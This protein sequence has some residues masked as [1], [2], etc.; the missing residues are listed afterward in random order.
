[1]SGNRGELSHNNDL[2]SGLIASLQKLKNLETL[3][4]SRNRLEELPRE[5]AESLQNMGN[6]H[7]LDLSQNGLRILPE[8]LDFFTKLTSL[9]SLILCNNSLSELPPDFFTSLKSLEN[10]YVINLADNRLTTL[11]DNFRELPRQMRL[12]LSGNNFSSQEAERILNITREPGYNGPTINLSIQ[13][14][15]IELQKESHVVISEL[16]QIAKLPQKQLHLFDSLEL[17]SWLNRLSEIP[18]FSSETNRHILAKKIL[19][20][21]EE[22]SINPSFKEAFYGIIQ[23]ASE[24]CG[25]RVALSILHLDIQ[26]QLAN[27]DVSDMSNLANFLTQGVWA[28]DLLEKC[29]RKKVEGLAGIDEI[30]TYL[31]YPIYLKDALDIPIVQEEMLYFR[32]SGVTEEDLQEAKKFVLEHQN[33][34]EKQLQFLLSQKTWIEALTI[35]H[36][37]EMQQI[38]AERD[39]LASQDNLDAEAYSRIQE[40]YN[41]KLLE[42]SRTILSQGKAV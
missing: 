14:R 30:E 31:A 4:L 37:K 2:P 24:T 34:R 20:I 22:A 6:L 38:E 16:Y 41:T 7:T 26:H 18:E 12:I 1:M 42:L 5:F 3:A 19:G 32:C 28:L 8:N 9:Y 33:D 27:M 17:K 36:P 13:D 29:A 11:P 15:M 23:D 40:E 39:K 10:L 21:L 25:D 35:N